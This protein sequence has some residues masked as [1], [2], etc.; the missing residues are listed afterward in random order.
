MKNKELNNKL[1]NIIKR[2][3]VSNLNELRKDIIIYFDEL[4]GK[5][6]DIELEYKFKSIVQTNKEKKINKNI[7]TIDIETYS[8]DNTGKQ[9]VRSAG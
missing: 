3:P 7:G 1:I 4:T 5:I 9:E 2:N 6:I 8:V